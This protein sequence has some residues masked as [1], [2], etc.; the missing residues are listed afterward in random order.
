[1]H[2]RLIARGVAKRSGYR[3]IKVLK[4]KVRKRPVKYAFEVFCILDLAERYR[5]K[6]L[7]HVIG[8]LEVD[9]ARKNSD[10]YQSRS[11]GKCHLTGLQRLDG[12]IAFDL[13]SLGQDTKHF[14]RGILFSQRSVLTL[15]NAKPVNAMQHGSFSHVLPPFCNHVSTEDVLLRSA[16]IPSM[17]PVFVKRSNLFINSA[18]ALQKHNTQ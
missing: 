14:Q 1:V 10:E 15:F 17:L 5:D 6:S 18:I 16:G 8:R 3:A 9:W 13:D 4:V 7:C 2:C 12:G 11:V